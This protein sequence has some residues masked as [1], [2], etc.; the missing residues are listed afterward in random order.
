MA[1]LKRIHHLICGRSC[2]SRGVPEVCERVADAYSHAQ[3]LTLAHELYF[4]RDVSGQRC[5]G[6]L[7][8]DDV[9]F[10]LAANDGLAP[11]PLAELFE[12]A[13]PRVR[14]RVQRNLVGG[15][16]CELGVL[17][18]AKIYGIRPD[19]E[20]GK[21]AVAIEAGTLYSGEIVRVFVVQKADVPAVKDWQKW[22]RLAWRSRV[23][24]GVKGNVTETVVRN[25]LDLPRGIHGSP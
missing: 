16:S 2:D 9:T 4:A 19:P 15:P 12:L 18:R 5:P 20:N 14:Q 17:D 11:L 3:A 8:Q 24:V 10:D 25:F 7:V 1:A 13:L 6:F 21:G 22:D 23:T